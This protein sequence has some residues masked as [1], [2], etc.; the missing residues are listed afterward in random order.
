[1]EKVRENARGAAVLGGPPIQVRVDPR[2]HRLGRYAQRGEVEPVTEG[3]EDPASH[4]RAG[5][6]AGLL[7]AVGCHR[8][9][10]LGQAVGEG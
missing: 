4:V 9:V 2:L 6:L 1:M 7:G 10:V 3:R 8:D 5:Y